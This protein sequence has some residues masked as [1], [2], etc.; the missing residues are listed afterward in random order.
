MQN[1]QLG[2]E[3]PVFSR[4]VSGV[5]TWGVWGANFSVEQTE[6]YI[7]D[8]LEEGITTFDHADIYGHYTTEK[9]FGDATQGR[10][11]LR[12]KMQLVSKC[13][14]KL[15]T[16]NRP[17]HRIKSYDTSKEHIL[18]S[19]EN[20]LKYLRADYLDLLLIHRPSPLMHPAEV[21]EAF[22]ALHKA[23][24]VK[25]FGVSNFTP[26]QM[27]LFQAH[28]PLVTNQIE[29]SLGHRPSFTDGTL[30]HCLQT[31]VTPMAWSPLAGGK[32]FGTG[33]EE[34]IKR[35]RE[36]ALPLQEKYNAGLDQILL[37]WLLKHPSGI[38]P[39]LG[40]TK[41][42]RLRQAKG[43]LSIDLSREDWFSLLEAAE[44]SE[45]A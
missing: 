13:G 28:F 40:S 37:A 8:C 7:Q 33:E 4:I 27:R 19:A 29:L 45:V 12:D 31:G 11:S 25:Y 3:G 5:M 30:D 22:E 26:S 1:I 21:A 20:S 9:L 35:V 15:T 14:I 42:Q 16:P 36:A 24:K 10:S 44:G 23:G 34:E 6:K 38:I 18:L 39:V 41:I 43:A 17:S 32:F 2:K